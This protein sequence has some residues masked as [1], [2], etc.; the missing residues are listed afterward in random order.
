MNNHL[1]T[2]SMTVYGDSKAAKPEEEIE[3]A[4]IEITYG[5]SKAYRPDLKQVVLSPVVNGPGGI[6]LFMEPLNGN[7]SDKSGFHETIKKV[8]DFQEQI[9]VDKNFKWIA[10]SALYA[11]GKLLHMSSFNWLTR[12]PETIKEAKKLVEKPSSEIEWNEQDKGYKLAPFVSHYGGLSSGGCWYI[13]S[14]LIR[15]KRRH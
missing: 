11:E 2:T 1:D 6:P 7:N 14:R 15:E 3:P 8:H 10:D 5:Y 9:D 12:V 13:R 4:V